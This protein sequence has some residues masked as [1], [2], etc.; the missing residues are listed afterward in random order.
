MITLD[1]NA[2]TQG[3]IKDRFSRGIWGNF[4]DIGLTQRVHKS[5]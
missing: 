4:T 2:N 3:L 5:P 1:G